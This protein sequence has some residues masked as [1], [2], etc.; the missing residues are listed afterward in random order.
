MRARELAQRVSELVSLPAVHDRVIRLLD[1]TDTPPGEIAR[2]IGHDPGLTARLIKAANGKRYG[3]SSEIRNVEE[4]VQLIGVGEL[5][6]LVTATAAAGSFRSIDV[7]LVDMGDFWRHSACCGLV[8]RVLADECDACDPESLFVAGLLHD[9]GQLVI[10]HEL[11]ELAQK[12][13]EKAGADEQS[14]YHAEQEILGVS[15]AQVGAELLRLWGLSDS[16]CEAVE[17]HHEPAAAPHYPVDAAAVHLATGIANA[18]EPSWKN[19][20]LRQDYQ[21]FIKPEAWSFTG[22]SQEVIEPTLDAVSWD[23]LEVEDIVLPGSSCIY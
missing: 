20:R 2:V 16:L 3:A 7:K 21:R 13:L 22:L 14:R 9:I 17:F 5:R 12:V 23:L 11:P 18:F 8:A 6:T 4:A 1:A 10:Y 19:E 15:H